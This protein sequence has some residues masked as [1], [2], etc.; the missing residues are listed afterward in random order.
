MPAG[1]EPFSPA[2]FFP[3][4]WP[5]RLLPHRPQELQRHAPLL[6]QTPLPFEEDGEVVFDPAQVFLTVRKARSLPRVPL[7]H[8]LGVVDDVLLR[9]LDDVLQRRDLNQQHLHFVRVGLRGKDGAHLDYDGGVH[10]DVHLSDLVARRELLA[11]AEDGGAEEVHGVVR[12]VGHGGGG[13]VLAWSCDDVDMRMCVMR[14]RRNS[15]VERYI[16]VGVAVATLGE[17]QLLNRR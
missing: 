13:A 11:G 16:Y 4:L 7:S 5:K 3:A 12:G 2:H 14:E 8:L 6:T 9:H 10:V 1:P 15:L 17:G